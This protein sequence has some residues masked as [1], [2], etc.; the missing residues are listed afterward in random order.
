M[1]VLLRDFRK[2]VKKLKVVEGAPQQSSAKAKNLVEQITAD[3]EENMN[4]DLHVK[5]AFDSLYKTVS[6]L[7]ELKEKQMLSAEDSKEALAKIKDI[8]YV[9]QAFF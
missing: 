2:L 8:D 3:F 7:V 5:T 9:F 4:N 1:C 6:K